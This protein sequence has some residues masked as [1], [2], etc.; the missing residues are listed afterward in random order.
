MIQL[1]T[2]EY[3]SL[4]L[5]TKSAKE[6]NQTYQFPWT[7]TTKHS[8][9]ESIIDQKFLVTITQKNKNK[10]RN[11]I[12]GLENRKMEQDNTKVTK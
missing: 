7:S 11:P 9:P 2:N 6:D 1:D 4:R 5:S 8:V 12:K 3:E 10:K